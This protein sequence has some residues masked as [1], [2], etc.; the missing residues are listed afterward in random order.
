VI[1]NVLG[2]LMI[3]FCTNWRCRATDQLGVIILH[4]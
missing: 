4:R 2:G 1:L 3:N